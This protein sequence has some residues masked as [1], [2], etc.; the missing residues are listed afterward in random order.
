MNITYYIQKHNKNKDFALNS[1]MKHFCSTFGVLFLLLLSVS[2][3][4]QRVEMLCTQVDTSGDI[5]VSWKGTAIPA[6]YEY[7]LYVAA[8]I[9]GTYDLLEDNIPTTRTF[10]EHKGADG[11][12]EP[13]FYFVKAVPP[14]GANGLEYVSD[15]LRNITLFVNNPGGTGIAPLYWKHPSFPPLPS[16][17]AD[18]IILRG[19]EGILQQC[20]TSDTTYFVDT[21]YVCGKVIDYQI[22]LHDDRG[23]DNT[24]IV[25]SSLMRSRI[26][27][28]TPQLDSVSINPNTDKTELGW[29][30]SSSSFT[31]GYI[32][33]IYKNGICIPFDTVFGAE[34]THYIDLENDATETPQRY[35]IAAIDTCR[36]ASAMGETHNTLILSASNNNCDSVFHLSWNAYN[37]MPDS[38]TGYRIL[39]SENGGSFY[40]VDTVPS[41]KLNYSHCIG[42]NNFNLYTYYVQAYNLNNGYS[43]SST[44]SDVSFNRTENTAEVW[45]R[46]VSV[47]DN[48]NIEVAV[49]VEDTGKYNGLLLFRSDDN[50]NRFSK[51]D[52]KTRVKGQENYS[53]TDTK[54]DVQTQTYL[55]TVSL[56]DEC[57][58]TFTQSDTANNIVLKALDATSDMNEIQWTVYDGF[59]S[60]LDGYDVYRQLQTE[61]D[62]QLITNLPASQTDYAENVYGFASQGGKFYYQVAATEDNTNPYG[63]RDKSFSN[64]VELTKSPQSFIPNAFTPNGDGLNDIFKP[65]LTYVDDEEYVF[66]IFDRWGNLIF[67]TEEITVGWDGN[68]NGKP[69]AAG[70]YAYSLTYRQSE[71]KMYKTQGHVT[72]IR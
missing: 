2:S 61:I 44:K 65:V 47:A 28:E 23:C 63:F 5:T 12:S 56:T 41:S 52:E 35:R 55:Y 30:P 14:S 31:F 10:S 25:R 3:H 27:P 69:A 20:A 16:Q 38:L 37:N 64:S 45:L 43:A 9:E 50:G 7:Q 60:R 17:D 32:I 33:Y 13:W 26:P 40:I 53:F 8:A 58:D 62:F 66:S 6:N 49:F 24:S 42:V 11:G 48:K 72:L 59:R 19:E 70:I 1:L 34:N 21:V 4:A 22:V 71:T 57:Y 68:I 51:I 18:F 15:T 46:Y 39:A 67:Y 29:E 36:N 54:V